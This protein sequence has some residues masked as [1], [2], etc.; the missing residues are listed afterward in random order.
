MRVPKAVSRLLLLGFAVMV[1]AL[2]AQ[3]A[4]ADDVYLDFACS[5]VSSCNGNIVSLPGGN[6][7]TTGITVTEGSGFYAPGSQFTM[8]FDTSAM[9]ISLTGLGALSGEVFTGVITSFQPIV[10][11]STVDINFLADWPVIPTD[12]QTYFN[13]TSGY[14]SGF[15]I[16]LS[17]SNAANSV[18]VTIT[19]APEPAAPLLL[20]AALIGLGLLVKRK[21]LL[22]GATVA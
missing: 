2:S 7:S 19:P 18:D 1:A 10:A 22:P 15:A 12:V 9:T 13:T 14:D 11:N 16:F 8:A 20:S 6:F 3:T 21:G 17:S 4:R 5:G